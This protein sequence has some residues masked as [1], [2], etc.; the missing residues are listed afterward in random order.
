M[1]TSFLLLTGIGLAAAAG[2]N[3]YIPLLIA[4]LLVHFEV[5]AV[6]A[7][8]DLLGT[9]PALIIIGV[10]LAVELLADKI[11]AIDSV[12][13][14]VQTAMRPAS[15]ALLFAAAVGGD[16]TWVQALALIAGLVTAGTV[17]GAKSTAR[18]VVNASTAGVG[19]PVVSVIED[20]T[21]VALTLAAIFVPVLVLVLLAALVW[22]LVSMR[23]RWRNR[24]RDAT[25]AAT[26]PVSTP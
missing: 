9:T 13:D 2:L 1:D 26:L 21:S 8:Y 15:G 20:V 19:G 25:T 4:G 12:N 18:P 5:I 22:M 6:E 10:L 14:V 24:R 11:P 16:A 7:P 17:H 23:R 3:A